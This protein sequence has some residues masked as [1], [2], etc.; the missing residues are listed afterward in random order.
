[1]CAVQNSAKDDL[2]L[3]VWTGERQLLIYKFMARAPGGAIL[4]P[5]SC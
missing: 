5:E 4:V 3:F 1:M 2:L